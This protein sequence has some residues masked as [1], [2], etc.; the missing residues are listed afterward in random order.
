MPYPTFYK[1]R[2]THH[3]IPRPSAVAALLHGLRHTHPADDHS[4]ALLGTAT[5]PVRQCWS[6]RTGRILITGTIRARLS[7]L[8]RTARLEMPRIPAARQFKHTS[9]PV[10]ICP[11]PDR[12]GAVICP[13]IYNFHRGSAVQY[14]RPDPENI[15][16][17]LGD[18]YLT[19]QAMLVS[20]IID[21]VSRSS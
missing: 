19:S 21:P 15:H 4:S 18:S 3:P 8:L 2:G 14:L 16:Q 1:P 5:L 12:V 13:V 7:R 20:G 9:L 10:K 6:Q 11:G 17:T